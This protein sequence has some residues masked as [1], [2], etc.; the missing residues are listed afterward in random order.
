MFNTE[1]VIRCPREIWTQTLL[2]SRRKHSIV[3]DALLSCLDK[4]K[5]KP[6]KQLSYKNMCE[7][8][9]ED[10][11]DF[12]TGCPLSY[13]EIAHETSL[14]AATQKTR[15]TKRDRYRTEQRL[16]TSK[17]LTLAIREGK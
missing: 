17:S 2:Y 1:R 3:A 4:N 15:A 16:F 14:D 8:Y 12:P 9:A 10:P 7:L 6:Y 11:V 5:N 13:A